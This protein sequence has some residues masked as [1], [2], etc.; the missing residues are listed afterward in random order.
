MSIYLTFAN[1]YLC[2]YSISTTILSCQDCLPCAN[3]NAAQGCMDCILYSVFMYSCSDRFSNWYLAKIIGFFI[4]S[5]AG[6]VQ[7]DRR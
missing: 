5:I 3:E 2:Q 6:K 1:F 7:I 4:F